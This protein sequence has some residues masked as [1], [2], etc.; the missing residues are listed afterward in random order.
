MRAEYRSSILLVKHAFTFDEPNPSRFPCSFPLYL[1]PSLPGLVLRVPFRLEVH[2]HA[3]EFMTY[4]QNGHTSK[5]SSGQMI[6]G[7]RYV[8]ENQLDSVANLH[9]LVCQSQYP[10]LLVYLLHAPE[11]DQSF[12]RLIA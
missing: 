5:R 12:H 8:L 1:S 3:M 11:H 9:P 7:L 10:R 6:L 2:K 4:E